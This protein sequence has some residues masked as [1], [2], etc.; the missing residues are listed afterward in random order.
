MTIPYSEPELN[1]DAFNCPL[2][3]TY[4]NFKW[5]II[6]VFNGS[7]LEKGKESCTVE[8]KA[9]SQDV[10]SSSSRVMLEEL[11]LLA[12]KRDVLYQSLLKIFLSEKI[13]EELH[14]TK[15]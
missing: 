10:F 12:N 6:K 9:I 11:K 15:A 8:L 3:N 13:D 1:K 4:A 2:C 14:L 5:N 7:E